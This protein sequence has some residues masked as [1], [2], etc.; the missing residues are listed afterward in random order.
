M[1][2]D[3]ILE[4]INHNR[5]IKKEAAKFFKPCGIKQI[6]QSRTFIFDNGWYNILIEFQPSAYSNGT[7]LNIGINFNWYLS[8]HF[9]FDIGY[10]ENTF[11]ECINEKQ[12]TEEIRR[13]SEKSITKINEY[14]NSLKN[15]EIAEKFIVKS[16]YTSDDLWGNYHRGMISGL[17][18][19]VD[20]INKYFVKILE[21]K[22]SL[23]WVIDLKNTV[24]KLIEIANDNIEL[25][26]MMIIDIIK[27][28]RKAKKLD[29]RKIVIE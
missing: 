3:R 17:I 16:K 27:E 14:R 4:K 1:D 12:F 23:E 13:L 26:N 19:N 8:D 2:K 24:R 28:T 21:N 7:L 20:K 9:S 29:E 11:V 18:G 25:F 10:R 15:I 5:I 22:E 6:G